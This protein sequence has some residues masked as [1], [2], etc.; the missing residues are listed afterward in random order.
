[1]SAG[2]FP[3]AQSAPAPSSHDE[4]ENDDSPA[5]PKFLRAKTT[6]GKPR[7]LTSE[8]AQTIASPVRVQQQQ[9]QPQLQLH[10][11]AASANV[12]DEYVW[13]TGYLDDDGRL[14][15][16]PKER[17]PLFPPPW[18]LIMPSSAWKVE[19]NLPLLVA[20][21]VE[22]VTIRLSRAY[23]SKAA[24]ARAKSTAVKRVDQG[25]AASST[26]MTATASVSASSASAAA[27]TDLP[28]SLI[29][30]A[31]VNSSS[32]SA[33]S[34]GSGGEIVDTDYIWVAHATTQ[35]VD[36]GLADD[37][38]ECCD[39]QC[40]DWYWT[41]REY[42]E[43]TQVWHA[44]VTL[45]QWVADLSADCDGDMAWLGTYEFRG[46]SLRLYDTNGYIAWWVA[47]ILVTLRGIGQV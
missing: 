16:P 5:T 26:N 43:T 34:A 29:L 39:E 44:G 38:I 28:E 6:R 47:F 46:S 40:T 35:T 41:A 30:T 32:A 22:S 2:L 25:A 8:Q 7:V 24:L 17:G 11:D 42:I 45:V 12:A 21:P 10:G 3:R 33:S 9:Q 37:I 1:M 31:A 4:E 27:S 23:H 19:N 18:A 15:D 20:P 36:I 13:F 14:D